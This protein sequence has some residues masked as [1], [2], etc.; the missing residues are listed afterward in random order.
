MVTSKTG[1][2]S[3]AVSAP[4]NN[5]SFVHLFSKHNALCMDMQFGCLYRKGMSQITSELEFGE[6]RR[7]WVENFLPGR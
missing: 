7:R 2:G 1:L 6:G 5:V 4:W 3:H